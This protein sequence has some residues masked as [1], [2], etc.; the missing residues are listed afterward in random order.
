VAEAELPAVHLE[1]RHLANSAATLTDPSLH[2]DLVRPWD[3]D[4]WLVAGAGSR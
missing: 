4:L 3:S 1:V 2:Y